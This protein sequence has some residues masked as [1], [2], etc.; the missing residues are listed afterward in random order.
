[1]LKQLH[2]DIL[3]MEALEQ[4]PN[5]VKFFKDILTNKRK[6][7]EFKTVALTQECSRMLQNK[8][9]QKMKDLGSFT[10]PSSIGTKYSGKALYNMGLASVSCLY[11]FLSN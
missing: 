6:L 2:I 4:M 9:P 3:F 8:I 10:I 11:P 7:G 1:M 5:Y